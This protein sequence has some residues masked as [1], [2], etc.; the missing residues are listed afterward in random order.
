MAYGLQPVKSQNAA[1]WNSQSNRYYIASGYNTDLFYGDPVYVTGSGTIVRAAAG[2]GQVIMGV[3]LGCKYTSVTQSINGNQVFSPYWPAGTVTF[4]AQNAEA[5]VCD[6]PNTV[7]SVQSNGAGVAAADL[8]NNAN[9]AVGAGSTISGLSGFVLDVAS[10]GNGQTKQLKIVDIAPIP[11]NNAGA[12][13]NYVWVVLNQGF[14][15]GAV[16]GGTNTGTAG[17]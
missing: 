1:T 17:V 11:G 7:F 9:L 14:Y 8:Y 10:I 6:D 12:A 4:Q 5:I 13:A 3:F 2:D 16:V 15:K